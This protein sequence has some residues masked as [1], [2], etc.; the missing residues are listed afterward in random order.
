MSNRSIIYIDGFNLYYGLVKDTPWKWL[1][2]HSYFQKRRPHDDI[3]IIKYFTAIAKNSEDQDKYLSALSTLPLVRI[4]YGKFKPVNIECKH[5]DC[6][7][8]GDRIFTKQEEKRTDVNIAI[9]MLNDAC[10]DSCDRLV[11]VSGDSDLVPALNMIKSL[12][13]NKMLWVYVPAPEMNHKRAW[14]TELRKYSD[15]NG[16]LVPERLLEVCQLPEIVPYGNDDYISKP[17]SW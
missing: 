4:I 11:L 15:K 17:A 9:H 1:D 16:T 2:I 6:D 3:K 13:P 7:Y 5:P 14:A 12:V 8:Q 10:S